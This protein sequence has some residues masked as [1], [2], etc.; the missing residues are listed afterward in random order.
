MKKR[1]GVILAECIA[2]CAVAV[3][4]SAAAATLTHQAGLLILTAHSNYR[5]ER[6]AS[7]M[8]ARLSSGAYNAAQDDGDCKIEIADVSNGLVKY[9][10][11]CEG[12]RAVVVRYVL[13]PAEQ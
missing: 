4:M 9:R 11:S 13:W 3:L 5:V 7:N 12:P 6:A 2:A 1:R 8:T 10:I